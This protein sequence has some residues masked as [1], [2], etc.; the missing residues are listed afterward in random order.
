MP[1]ASSTVTR[2]EMEPAGHPLAHRRAFVYQQAALLAHDN[3]HLAA[4]ELA[5]LLAD[6]GHYAQAEQLLQQVAPTRAA[7]GGLSQSGP[8]AKEAGVFPAGGQ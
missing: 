7:P 8:R 3:N 1:S 5:V 2:G 6:A 4:H